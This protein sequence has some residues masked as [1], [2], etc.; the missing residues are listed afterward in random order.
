GGARWYKIQFKSDFG[1]VLALAIDTACEDLPQL[2][3]DLTYI[4]GMEHVKAFEVE[5]LGPFYGAPENYLWF[6]RSLI[7]E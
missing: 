1:W 5:M 3:Y 2:S 7:E 4:T 6:Y